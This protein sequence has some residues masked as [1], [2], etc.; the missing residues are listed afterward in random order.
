M[1]EFDDV[2]ERGSKKPTEDE[3]Q[4]K[5]RIPNFADVG[6][7]KD[8]PKISLSSM[9]Q[10]EPLLADLT[11]NLNP[12]L[13]TQVL[14]PLIN[15]FEKYGF[16]ENLV[17]S[18]KTQN[19]LALMGV[20]T[21]VAPVIKGLSQYLEGHR[22]SL[23]D[24]D[25]EFLENLQNLD[26]N[27]DLEGLF[28]SE[29]EMVVESPQREHPLLGKLPDIDATKKVDW[30]KIMDPEGFHSG[31][32]TI[33]GNF[34]IDDELVIPKNNKPKIKLA[35]VEELA[36]QAGIDLQDNNPPR[37]SYVPPPPPPPTTEVEIAPVNIDKFLEV[38]PPTNVESFDIPI[39]ERFDAPQTYYDGTNG[40]E[41]DSKEAEPPIPS[42]DLPS[43]RRTV[44][45]KWQNFEST[46]EE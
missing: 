4:K 13:K 30:M 3:P 29:N 27:E 38:S 14:I 43:A 2:I 31:N 20:L 16:A 24:A 12:E 8:S 44:V 35:S 40:L 41:A 22:N 23:N 10:D 17:S 6:V 25:K 34:T 5:Q 19:S 32:K 15:I 28:N 11:N 18:E 39:S 45:S 33:T 1:S 42:V 26:T 37:I 46:E 36:A 7:E 9:L 21:D